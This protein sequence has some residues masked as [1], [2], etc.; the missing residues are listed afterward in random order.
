L[1]AHL[2][3]RLP[4]Y[5]VPAGL[6]FIDAVPLSSNGKVDRRALVPTTRAAGATAP[7]GAL[8][9]AVAAVVAE[10]MPEVA[11]DPQR[12]LFEY[13]ASSLTLVALQRL[14]GERLGRTLP[15]QRIFEAPTIAGFAR[16]LA[17]GDAATSPVVSFGGAEDRPKLLMMPGMFALPFYLRDMAAAVADDLDLVSVQ[18]PGLAEGETPLDDLETQAE[19]VIARLRAAGLRG[20]WLIGGHSFGGHVALAVGRRLRAAGEPVPLLLLGD[21]VRTFGDFAALQSDDLAY[22][23]MTRGLAAL[24][25]GAM[26]PAEGAAPE[27]AFRATAARM[28]AAGLF[29]ALS[30]PLDR[31]AA[32]FKANFRAIGAARHGA[33][34][35]DLAVL[36]SEGGFPAEFLQFETGEAAADP[37]LGW[38]P[39]VEGRVVTRTLRGDHLAMLDAANLPTMATIVTELARDALAAHLAAIGGTPDPAAGPAALWRAIRA[40]AR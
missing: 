37:A 39:L 18:L 31:M 16:G 20:P 33:V 30:L 17:G 14:L 23:A 4:A 1:L 12:S 11:V 6:T 40:R 3:D 34:P 28:Q 26:P 27:A 13:G 19:Y 25:G 36:R 21:T 29:G 7:D 2:R 24:Y 32:L 38:A 8:D 15:L 9:R 5:M 22:A 35:G 10:I